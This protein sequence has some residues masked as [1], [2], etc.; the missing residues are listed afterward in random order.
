MK[1]VQKLSSHII[2]NIETFIE[3]DKRYKKHCSHD[4]DASVL[5]KAGTWGPHTVL[6]IAISCPVTFLES[7]RWSEI[8]SLSKVIF[9]FGKSQ[10]VAVHQIWAVRGL[11]PLGDLIF[12]FLPKNSAWDMMHEQVCCH[13]KAA[14]HQ[15]PLAAAFWIIWIVSVEERSSLTQNWM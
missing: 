8:C 13:D 6:P 5:F 7:H 9:S 10:K 12:W 4:N 2:L 14:N 11:S 1:S 3:E 15:L